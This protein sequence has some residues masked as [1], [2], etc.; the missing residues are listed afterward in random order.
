[1]KFKYLLAAS[2]SGI[3][4]SV[5]LPAPAAAQQISSSIE[6]TVVSDDGSALPGATVT[7]LDSRT[8]QQRVTITD[9]NGRFRASGLLPGGPYTVTAR[10]EGFEGQAVEE[11]FISV[12]SASTYSFELSM[13]DEERTIVVTGE[14][15]RATQVANGPGIAF[16]QVSM[17]SFPS[18]S[19]DVRDIIRID[20]R[21]SIDRASEV[22]RISCLGGNDRGN[23][24]TVDGIVQADSFGLNG[25]PF[26]SRNAMPIPYD[27]IQETSIEFAPFDV[28]YSDFTGCLINVI[29]K[30]GGNDWHGTA[31]FSYRDDGLRGDTID[32]RSF[33]PGEFNEKRWGATLSGP[34]IK[35]RLWF[36]AGYE[37]TDLGGTNSF[38]PQ[39][40]GFPNEAE[41]VDVD[42]F[43]EFASIA[44]SVYGQDVGGYPRNLPESSVR[45]FGR[46]DGYLTD[47]HRFELTYQRLEET[48]VESDT[49]N[50]ELTGFNSFEDEGTISDYYSARI[51]SN[52]NDRL[53][54]ELRLS[55]SEVGDVQGPVG[56][57]EAQSDDPT[58]RLSVGVRQPDPDNPGEFN[59]G[60]LSTG[61]GI[62]RSANQLDTRVD[63]AKFQINYDAGDHQLTF[64][65]EVNDLSVYNLFAI[66]ATG[67]IFFRNLDD[68]AEGLAAAGDGSS[69]FASA[70]D[71][72]DGVDG[73]GNGGATIAA[74][75]SGDINE[76]AA[77][78]GRTIWSIYAQDDWQATD[79]LA[80]TAGVRVQFYEG[81][82]P[83]ENPN[84]IDRFGFSNANAFGDIDPVILPR[85]G[86]TYDLFDYDG[87]FSDTVIK[88]GVGVFSGGDPIVYF[89]NAFSNNGFNTANG[90]TFD[91]ACAGLLDMNGQFDVVTGG[92]FTGIPQCAIDS[93][94]GR[95]AVG[96]AAIQST[97]PDFTN[98]T[99]LRA[100]LGLSTTFG[101]GNGFFDNWRVDVDYIYSHFINPVN[102]VDLAQTVDFREGLN[103]YTVDG[104]P[105]YRS[106]DST[107]AGCDATLNGTGGTNFSWSNVTAECFTFSGSRDDELQL[108]NGPSYDSHVVS[109]ILSKQFDGGLFTELGGANISFGYAWMDSDNFRNTNSST[110]TSSFDESAMFDRQN[111]AVGT[112]NYETKHRFTFTVN[113][114]EEFF[115][116]YDTR[117]GLFFKARS[118]RPYSLTFDGGGNF[119]DSASG[120]DNNLLYIPT[121]MSDPNVSP[122]SDPDA[123]NSLLSYVG[124][125]G[126]AD[127]YSGMT[128]AKNTCTEDWVYDLD[129][130]ISQEIPGFMQ[131]FGGNDRFE[132]FADIDNVLNLIDSEWNTFRTIGSF[133]DGQLVDIV[134]GDYDDQ[135]RYIITGF[136]PDDDPSISINSSAWRIQIGARYEF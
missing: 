121:G 3:A 42:Q 23:T 91:S 94:S 67:T 120:S 61:P 29:T 37:E 75:G 102:W 39:G 101:N 25:T 70:D 52:W 112:S 85:F 14:R 24:F 110:A 40:D 83:R 87:L 6:G 69:V 54:T 10:L 8:G 18:V 36:F 47:D 104:K 105:I 92:A 53:S 41:F 132:V 133:G 27:V 123:V 19:R 66:N 63:Q 117:V 26:A 30:S 76:A 45:Y 136:N 57:G 34:I 103:G 2:L 109:L 96:G 38:G 31:F 17:E 95:A 113:L 98:P 77:T 106:I 55:R 46:L 93:A 84:F 116:D 118:G 15:A 21:V 71:L 9:A 50:D 86:F 90:S 28:E 79:Q 48:N 43:D 5:V 126:C 62:F 13:A 68:F 128:I 122:L 22:D 73:D 59:N 100:N 16:G 107:N 32:G 111:P 114:R 89:S 11:Q 134:D 78:F 131:F 99:V 44:A 115:E 97:D 129:L 33:N 82:A 135:G 1:M 125:L 12:Q 80:I 49:A 64:G 124:A 81:D 7:I 56:F 35:D 65:A 74:T 88:G 60:I 4:A 119:I 127:G 72:V 130:R 51:F 58:I 108:T 20:P